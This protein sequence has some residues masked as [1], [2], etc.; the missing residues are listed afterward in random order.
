MAAYAAGG[1]LSYYDLEFVKGAYGNLIL[2]ATPDGPER[3]AGEPCP[4]MG[5][6]HLA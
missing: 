6:R 5:R 2:F 3:M 1:L 4:P